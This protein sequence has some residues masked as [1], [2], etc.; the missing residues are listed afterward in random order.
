MILIKYG[1]LNGESADE[2]MKKA[3]LPPA[4]PT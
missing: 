1:L 2:K 3:G 4:S